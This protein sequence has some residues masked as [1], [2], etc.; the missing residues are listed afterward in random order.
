MLTS[1]KTV[2]KSDYGVWLEI[3]L[4]RLVEN[5]AAI[6]SHAPACSVLAVVKANAYGHG[7]LEVSRAL[8][9][10]VNFLGVSSVSEALELKEY[11]V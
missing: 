5:L 4:D 11:G 9:P 2:A 3:Q 8:A 10:L 6:R 7:F 1:V